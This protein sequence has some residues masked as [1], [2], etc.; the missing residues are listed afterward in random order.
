MNTKPSQSSSS[1]SSKGCCRLNQSL[2]T[3]LLLTVFG[4]AFGG[5]F[6]AFPE[7]LGIRPENAAL[8]ALSLALSCG[9]VG[10]FLCAKGV[11]QMSKNGGGLACC[12]TNKA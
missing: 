11:V 3:G 10:A 9:A 4:A 1:C 5:F 6:Y 2:C 8:T 7:S 12:S